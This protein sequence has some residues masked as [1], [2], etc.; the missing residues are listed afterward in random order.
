MH[1]LSTAESGVPSALTFSFSLVA[2]GT[3]VEDAELEM[4]EVPSAG[5]RRGCRT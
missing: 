3:P 5:L 2:Q 4:E 1:E